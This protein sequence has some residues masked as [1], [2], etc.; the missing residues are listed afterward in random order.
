MKEITQKSAVLGIDDAWTVNQP[1]GISLLVQTNSGWRCIGLAP[2]YEQFMALAAGKAV[3]WSQAPQGS[4]P[5]L[6]MLVQAALQLASPVKVRV[7]AVDMP[8]S[9]QKISGRRAA[10]SAISKGV[11]GKRLFCAFTK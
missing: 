3:D 1:S 7:I 10:D 11:W 5:D 4:E 2:S 6:E 9:L 8:V